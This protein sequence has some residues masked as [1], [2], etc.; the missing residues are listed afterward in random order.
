MKQPET[1]QNIIPEEAAIIESLFNYPSLEKVFDREN[2]YQLPLM[3]QKMT[4]TIEELERVVR[5]GS[6]QDAAK[7]AK[8]ITAYQTALSFL[9]ELE[10]IRQ[11]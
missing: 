1:D 11:T 2:V 4:A 6:Q 5:R 10:A 7:A 3:K 9:S 8:V